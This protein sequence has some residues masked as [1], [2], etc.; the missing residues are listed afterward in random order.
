MFVLTHR[1][2]RHMRIKRDI[3]SQYVSGIPEDT[4]IFLTEVR[5]NTDIYIYKYTTILHCIIA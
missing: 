2:C 5:L 3:T 1:E 4:S